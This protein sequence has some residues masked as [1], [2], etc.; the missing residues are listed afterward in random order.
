MD[1]GRR[2]NLQPPFVSDYPPARDN[3]PPPLT[4][5]ASAGNQGH[6]S[7]QLIHATPMPSA[8]FAGFR[9]KPI[10]DC[11]SWLYHH[12]C[13]PGKQTS[14]RAGIAAVQFERPGSTKKNS[15]LQ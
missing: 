11:S 4:H 15:G 2:S 6:L 7:F 9:D 10:I 3:L 13:W 14:H 12:R 8:W 5:A 1:G